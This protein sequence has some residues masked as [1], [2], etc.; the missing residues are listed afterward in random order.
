[1]A[2]GFEITIITSG[3]I[4]SLILIPI[5][6]FT[7]AYA[8]C[9]TKKKANSKV[10]FTKQD[11]TF[12]VTIIHD[13]VEDTSKDVLMNVY[14]LSQSPMTPKQNFKNNQTYDHTA[15]LS[16]DVIISPNP[17]YN[18]AKPNETLSESLYI[19]CG[20]PY[21]S[22]DEEDKA[23]HGVNEG[24][25]ALH[26]T[27]DTPVR[28]TSYDHRSRVAQTFEDSIQQTVTAA[29]EECSNALYQAREYENSY[30]RIA[31]EDQNDGSNNSLCEVREC[32][33]ALYIGNHVPGLTRSTSYDYIPPQTFEDFSQQVGN[34]G[35]KECN[36]A[37]YEAREYENVG[38]DIPSNPDCKMIL[39][40]STSQNSYDYVYE[41]YDDDST[42]DYALVDSVEV[43]DT[44]YQCQLT[45]E[46][47][48][49]AVNVNPNGVNRARGGY[50]NPSYG[51]RVTMLASH[52]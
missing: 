47:N 14:Q 27:G 34:G 41:A 26:G 29:R 1:M 17:S 48:T 8:C 28:Y 50:Q 36:N 2:D 30:E 19:Y 37:L 4:L 5:I 9:V 16:S 18:V 11:D 52:N 3:G 32:D 10:V 24:S 20:Q 38:H 43:S 45:A 44:P 33:N 15:S 35:T 21:A 31:N 23:V 22:T 51:H 13:P 46:D 7:V 12:K 40:R 49:D 39:T 25:N 42:H 6:L